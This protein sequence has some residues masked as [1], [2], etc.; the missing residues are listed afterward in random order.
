MDIQS[1]VRR[2]CFPS[3]RINIVYGLECKK[4]VIIQTAMVRSVIC[5]SF[6]YSTMKG[7][8]FSGGNSIKTHFTS[9]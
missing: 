1:M 8:T 9:F 7:Y 5:F 4:I 6:I 3:F 2:D